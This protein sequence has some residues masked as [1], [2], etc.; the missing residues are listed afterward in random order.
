[1]EDFRNARLLP[2]AKLG[3]HPN[4][5]A[6]YITDVSS[7][8]DTSNRRGR[9]AEEHRKCDGT[10]PSARVTGLRACGLLIKVVNLRTVLTSETVAV[11]SGMHLSF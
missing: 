3:E 8:S 10:L 2:R 7:P 6:P 11:A 5:E 9:R 4:L 1:M